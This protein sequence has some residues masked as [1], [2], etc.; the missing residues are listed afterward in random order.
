MDVLRMMARVEAYRIR[1]GIRVGD[2]CELAE[3]SQPTWRMW[4]TGARSPGLGN[5]A[6]ALDV[7]GL[8]LALVRKE[9][10]AHEREA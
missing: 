7:L 8:D 10:A 6:R 3:I 2:L 1:Q 9:G 4:L 5:L